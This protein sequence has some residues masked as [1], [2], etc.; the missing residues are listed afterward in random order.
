MPLASINGN[1]PF[2]K[3]YGKK[4]NYEH[5]KVFGC[6][7]YASNLKRE[8]HKFLSRAHQSVFLWY[9]MHKKGYKVYNT[10]SHEVSITKDVSF[11]EQFL[12]FQYIRSI[13]NKN[14]LDGI[15]L[16]VNNVD[17][18]GQDWEIYPCLT[19]QDIDLT[20]VTQEDLEETE[21]VLEQI[22]ST[23]EQRCNT[24]QEHSTNNVR[25]SQRLYRPPVYL[26]DHY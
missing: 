20:S 9:S 22:E 13:S 10:D 18:P 5:M 8:R 23:K 3:L 17:S 21:N 19:H 7:C 6:L 24:E 4:P 12:P 1:T 2:E 14:K 26:I 16:P 11:Y 15:F 25:K